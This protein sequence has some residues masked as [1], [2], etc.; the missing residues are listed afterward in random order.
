M[1]NNDQQ[2]VSV[3]RCTKEF[4][5]EGFWKVQGFLFSDGKSPLGSSGALSHQ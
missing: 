5:L 1:V 3:T 2:M 4:L